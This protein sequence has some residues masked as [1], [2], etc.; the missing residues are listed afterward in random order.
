MTFLDTFLYATS[1]VVSGRGTVDFMPMKDMGVGRTQYSGVATTVNCR[2]NTSAGATQ[3]QALWEHSCKI[4]PQT[5]EP[6]STYHPYRTSSPDFTSHINPFTQTHRAHYIPTS[7]P[8]E[9]DQAKRGQVAQI[10]NG[11][12]ENIHSGEIQGLIA[13]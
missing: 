5:V 1:Y 2:G 3:L 8:S 10:L 7:T 13:G 12:W 9:T 11:R 6:Y 4:Y